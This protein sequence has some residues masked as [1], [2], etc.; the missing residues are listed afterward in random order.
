[1]NCKLIKKK[2]TYIDKETKKERSF[3]S[4]YLLLDNGTTIQIR[5]NVYND[6]SG[7]F[8]SNENILFALASDNLPF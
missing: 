6:K 3:Y 2:V 8:I 1:M 7:R 5:P 4:Y